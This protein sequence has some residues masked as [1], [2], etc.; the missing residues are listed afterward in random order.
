MDSDPLTFRV[1]LAASGNPLAES[2]DGELTLRLGV[3]CADGDAVRDLLAVLRGAKQE[4]VVRLVVV[5]EEV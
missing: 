5:K 2:R 3:P 1:Y 4:Q